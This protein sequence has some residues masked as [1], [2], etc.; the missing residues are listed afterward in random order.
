MYNGAIQHDM[1]LIKRRTFK[2]KWW[3]SQVSFYYTSDNTDLTPLL[4]YCLTKTHGFNQAAGIYVIRVSG[5]HEST[6]YTIGPRT[7]ENQ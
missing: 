6:D 7:N 2:T 4:H 3:P 1:F 5:W